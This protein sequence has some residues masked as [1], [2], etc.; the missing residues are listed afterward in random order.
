MT[1][2]DGAHLGRAT[3]RRAHCPVRMDA[4]VGWIQIS[5]APALGWIQI[6]S[7]PAQT[8][9]YMGSLYSQA[10]LV[11][12]TTCHTIRK[13]TTKQPGFLVSP[14]KRRYLIDVSPKRVRRMGWRSRWKVV[15]DNYRT[16]RITFKNKFTTRYSEY[17]QWC[18][19]FTNRQ[20]LFVIHA[21][22]PNKSCSLTLVCTIL[23]MLLLLSKS[24]NVVVLP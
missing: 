10:L 3:C 13:I 7:A 24:K 15:S 1:T 19:D 11:V 12:Q 16:F 5:R 22:F 17:S 8:Q 4:M 18:F 21:D 9:Q 6:S 2:M 14:L 23:L 20:S